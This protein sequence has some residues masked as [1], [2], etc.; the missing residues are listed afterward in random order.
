MERPHEHPDVMWAC[1]VTG[2]GK[3]AE[4]EGRRPG[5]ADRVPGLAGVL[6]ALD[7]GASLSFSIGARVTPEGVA[8]SC[9]VAG[10]TQPLVEASPAQQGRQMIES[11][12]IALARGSELY[13]L[14]PLEAPEA[15]SPGD[16]STR[17]ESV[18][19]PPSLRLSP[20]G[21]RHIGFRPDA[22]IPRDMSMLITPE[23]CTDAPL[24]F[25]DVV[26]IAERC[27]AN[28]DITVSFVPRT[29]GDKE[30][31]ALSAMLKLARAG[32]VGVVLPPGCA[33]EIQTFSETQRQAVVE[34]MERWVRSGAGYR[35]S[36]RIAS[37]L[38]VDAALLAV[39]SEMAFPGF[40]RSLA[41][42]VGTPPDSTFTTFT[43]NLLD[44]AG[45]LP[46]PL[47]L[48]VPLP[49]ARCLNERGVARIVAGPDAPFPISG[50]M[51]GVSQ[52][53][54]QSRAVHLSPGDRMRHCYVCG[55]T[56]TGK[57]TLLCN[58]ISQDI[59]GGHGVV[60]ID[61]HGDLFRAVLAA[62]PPNRADEVVV[63]DLADEEWSVGLNFLERD[64]ANPKT[65]TT[66]I[67]N[68]L[69]K[70]FDRL[71]D[72]RLTGG[73]MFET[74]LRNSLLLIMESHRTTGTLMDVPRVFEDPK[75]RKFLKEQ[76]TNP[77]VERFWTGQ[78]E[79]AGGDAALANLA[80]YITS[81]L[82]QF[83]TNGLVTPIIGQVRSTVRFREFMDSRRI[84]LV[85][86]PMGVLG[87]M[88]TQLLGMLL[89]GKLYGAAM[90][91]A[92]V[93]EHE[94]V[95]CHVYID[96]FQ[97]FAT[98]TVAHVLAGARKFGLALCLANQNL[99]QLM[100]GTG[101]DNLLEA[102]L[103]N[104]GS[105]VCFRLGV[106][107]AERL[108]KYTSPELS[109]RDLQMLPNFRAAARILANNVPTRPFVLTTMPMATP[110]D[111]APVT[112]LVERSRELYCRR[113]SDVDTEIRESRQDPEPADAKGRQA[114]VTPV[115]SG[116]ASA[117]G[118]SVRR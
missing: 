83:T 99:S 90:G 103:G 76:C 52:G 53:S 7:P 35:I 105:L 24:W 28:L 74:Y 71:Y 59:R 72:L 4:T 118:Y 39:L 2:A 58:M 67:T 14:S 34:T 38:P 102:T 40:D 115:V 98:S 109:A 48:P 80:P 66:F 49:S 95:P 5:Q 17:H 85:N 54:R 93:P 61:P 63:I 12:R 81:K 112:G 82:N 33:Q 11:L 6:A 92:A 96:E 100:A 25:D 97:L 86:A 20:A 36:C 29:L 55:A 15:D 57:S 101:S 104:C 89:I 60:M 9:Q 110:T 27:G 113:A 65:Q 13:H 75:F 50:V 3:A 114:V 84:V 19:M 37:D 62:I 116:D 32:R 64:G 117:Q 23:P 42:V 10:A 111:A 44:L 46:S 79:R 43:A 88:N 70:I 56:G 51:L 73:P 1:E 22:S 68:E 21:P 108:E 91:R 47:T 18:L 41:S 31:R 94:R 30:L 77:V 106:S 69:M 107:D 87:E 8:M 16:H 45:C 78:A 26:R